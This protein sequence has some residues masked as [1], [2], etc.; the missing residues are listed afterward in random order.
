VAAP[1][2]VGWSGTI[3]NFVILNALGQ[4]KPQLASPA[5]DISV[6]AVE[7]AGGASGSV[8]IAFSDINFVNGGAMA[9]LNTE[10]S[11]VTAPDT[12]T[13]QSY[14]GNTNAIFGTGTLVGTQTG[15]ASNPSNQV[16][17]G[18]GPTAATYSMTEIET[19]NLAPGNLA[20]TDDGF[21]VQVAPVSYACP[22]S[23]GQ[24]GVVYS[25][26]TG[27]GGGQP[28]YAVTYTGVLP[29]GISVSPTSGVFSGTPTAVTPTGGDSF[30]VT[31][32]DSESN[33]I[34]VSCNIAIAPAAV[35]LT[36]TCPT[37]LNATVGTA[38]TAPTG[39][40]TSVVAAGGTAPYTYT[41]ASGSALPAGLLLASSTGAVSG[42]PTTATAGDSVTFSVTDN[43]SPTK[44]TTTAKCTYV[45]TSSSGSSSSGGS[46]G[47]SSSG[48]STKTA[49]TIACPRTTTGGQ[50]GVKFAA[51]ITVTGGVG[52][53]VISLASGSL[54]PG[55][56]LSSTTSGKATATATISGTPTNHGT[57]T[58]VFKVLDQGTGLSS[59]TTTCG[60]SCSITIAPAPCTV[61]GKTCS[62][63]QDWWGNWNN[64]GLPGQTVTCTGTDCF[65]NKV[66]KKCTTGND[67]SYCFSGLNPGNYS[68]TA[69]TQCYQQNQWGGWGSQTVQNS[70]C[71]NVAPDHGA[72]FSSC[73]FN[74]K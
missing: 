1:G 14:I 38:F 46:S 53:Y 9:S 44:Q 36:L 18:A 72:T 71:Y 73:N 51:T 23:S 24:V 29:S 6:G 34:T 7:N 61:S 37:D 30:T 31:A 52:P 64:Q 45:V 22:A 68:V 16:T 56:T 62:Q 59:T 49:P 50:E 69:P 28:P 58:A 47:G 42:T 26:S 12:V 70:N 41:V 48:G 57:Y 63:S 60:N 17:S 67:G 55:T 15:S 40:S 3:G 33:T 32:T 39:Q 19:F 13:F 10:T 4:T 21:S 25:S 66:S 5:L 20:I 11:L 27:V 8:S 74:Y 35:P 43:T 65:G 2:Q 54:P